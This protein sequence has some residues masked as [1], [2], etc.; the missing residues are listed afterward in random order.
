MTDNPHGDSASL[1][2]A[3]ARTLVGEDFVVSGDV[4]LVL[5][6]V[7][8]ER[9]RLDPT[10]TAGD[11]DRPFSLLFRGPSEPQLAQGMHDLEHP[12]HGFPGLFLVPMGPG[13]EGC[14][15]EAIFS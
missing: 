13:G 10:A 4:D 1:T 2:L 12:R 15:Y 8:A 14:H 5:R 7:E 11:S 9:V 6:L 3:A